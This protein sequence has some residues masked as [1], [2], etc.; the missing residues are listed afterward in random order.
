MEV[1]APPG[2]VLER[3]SILDLVQ[4]P[5]HL[6]EGYLDLDTQLQPNGFDMTLKEISRIAS[7]GQIPAG[8]APAALPEF[9]AQPFGPDDYVHLPQGSYVVT[10]NEVVNLPG[11]VMALARPRSS[12]LRCGVGLH[13]AVWDAGYHGRSQALLSV[14]NPLG[15]RVARDARILQMVFMYLARSLSVDGAYQGRF[16]GENIQS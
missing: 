2:S 3:D 4:G 13:T 7:A 14:H 6:V 1:V 11:H 10:L 5:G 15:F 8:A 16:Q 9:H 12:L